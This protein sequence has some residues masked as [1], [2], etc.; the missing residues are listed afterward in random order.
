MP[1]KADFIR[2][3]VYFRQIP[4][5]D[6]ENSVSASCVVFKNDLSSVYYVD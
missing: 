2:A 1:P 5:C 4:A 6:L 3:K